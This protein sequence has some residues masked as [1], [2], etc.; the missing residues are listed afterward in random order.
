MVLVVLMSI[1]TYLLFIYLLKFLLQRPLPLCGSERCT[2]T[3]S[4]HMCLY[5]HL[6]YGREPDARSSSGNP[7]HRWGAPKPNA[8]SPTFFWAIGWCNV[9]VLAPRRQLFKPRGASSSARY[10]GAKP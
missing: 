6:N 2:V 9:S 7:V 10:T 8:P 4:K 5:Q 3:E 1:K